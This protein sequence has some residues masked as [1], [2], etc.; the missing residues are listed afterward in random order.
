[1]PLLLFTMLSRYLEEGIEGT[2]PVG[3]RYYRRKEKD[4]RS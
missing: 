4:L 1:M 2:V 3:A